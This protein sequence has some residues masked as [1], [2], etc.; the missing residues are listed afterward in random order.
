[1]KRFVSILILLA[2]FLT[3]NA[4]SSEGSSA[5][6]TITDDAGRFIKVSAR[7]ER[8]VSIAPSNTEMLFALGVGD[9]VVGVTQYCNYPPETASVPKVGGFADI[10]IEKVVELQP[11]LVVA[12]SL[13]LSSIVPA[14][15]NLGLK[16]IVIN[17]ETVDGIFDSLIRLG[18]V[19]GHEEKADGMV[20]ELTRELVELEEKLKGKRKVKVFWELSPDLWTAGPNS[21]IHDLIERA[22]GENIAGDGAS[23]WLK[24]SREVIID[25]SPEIIFLADHLSGE[26]GE[27]VAARPGWELVSA[28]K[29]GRVIEIG[30]TDLLSRPGPRVIEALKYVAERIYPGIFD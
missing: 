8:I 28:V 12:A 15:E 19:T 2:A 21:F 13:H 27:T 17:P 16:V 5:V 25:R 1:M 26:N 22:G 10:S 29:E 24:L 18:I 9:K 4:G 6:D 11:D 3:I 20:K 7:V 30:D 23:P 14:L